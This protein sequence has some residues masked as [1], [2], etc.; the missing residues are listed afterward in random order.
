MS[1][2]TGNLYLL[3]RS[4]TPLK[5]SQ[6]DKRIKKAFILD[7]QT[8]FFNEE[9]HFLQRLC[10]MTFLKAKHDV[11]HNEQVKKKTCIIFSI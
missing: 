1:A 3:L 6:N 5:R 11:H 8:I 9:V 10:A 2:Q 7:F 4:I